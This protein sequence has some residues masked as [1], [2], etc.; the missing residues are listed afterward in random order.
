[1][2]PALIFLAFCMRSGLNIGI[3]HLL[4][5]LP[6]LTIFA[7]AGVWS[8]A[9]DRKWARIALVA[10]LAFQ[11]ISSLHAFPNYLSYAN[12]AWGGPGQTYRYLSHSD[13]DWGQAQKFVRA[14]VDKTHPSNCF[15]IRSYNNLNND[16]G[17][18]CRGI[19]EIQWDQLE[20]PFTG[21]LIAGVSAV[22]GVGF[23]GVSAE[24][25]RAL[26]D[27]QP[28][29]KLGG[30]AVLVYE[31]TFNVGPITAIQL[32]FRARQLGDED[33]QKILELAQQASKLDPLNGDAHVVMCSSY[34]LLGQ[35]DKAEQECNA[36]L[37][38]IH[39]DPQYGPEQIKYL[40]DFIT[41]KGL[42]IYSSAAT[43]Q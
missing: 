23:R 5:M 14:Y 1:M 9:C 22:N 39:K 4:P 28:T 35:T 7:A 43:P 19:S 31:G 30:S 12:E 2:L 40:E 37:A 42:K 20:S 25:H 24:V 32:L 27:I 21:T 18:S 38:L 15:Y 3:R 34:Q 41:K 26:K 17:I 29:A 36:G 11:A 33:P 10:L 13:V 6:L 16:Y 8:I